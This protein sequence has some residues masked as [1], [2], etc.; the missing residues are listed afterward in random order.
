[1]LDFLHIIAVLSCLYQFWG[2]QVKI[3]PGSNILARTVNA[4]VICVLIVSMVSGL[5][6]R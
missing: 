2:Q 1:M 3:Q 6:V 4:F 5:E